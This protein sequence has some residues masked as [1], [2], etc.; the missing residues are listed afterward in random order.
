MS[1]RE[2][3]WHDTNDLDEIIDRETKLDAVYR[4]DRRFIGGPRIAAKADLKCVRG[5]LVA[6]LALR[7][8]GGFCPVCWAKGNRVRDFTRLPS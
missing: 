5:H 7:R 8:V 1:V 6:T 4:S 2:S 3:W